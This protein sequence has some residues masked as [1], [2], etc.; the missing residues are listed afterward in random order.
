MFPENVAASAKRTA[1]DRRWFCELP[2][3]HSRTQGLC[4]MFSW[5]HSESGVVLRSALL[6]DG[7]PGDRTPVPGTWASVAVRGQEMVSSQGS[8]EA[9]DLEGHG[10]P[11][12]G[13]S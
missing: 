2:I 7:L 13:Q 11:G 8:K 4:G 9:G 6:C 5:A 10:S 12:S 1:Q 3:G